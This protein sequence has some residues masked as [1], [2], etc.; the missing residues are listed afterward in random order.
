MGRNSSN[1]KNKR[2]IIVLGIAGRTPFAGVAW[3][4]L[5]YLEGLRR[6]GHDVYYIEDTLQW[7][8]DLD[9]NAKT[10]DSGYTVTYIARLMA[11]CGMG[12][13]WAYRAAEQN[14]RI[15]GLSESEFA[16]VFEQAD[17]LIN[18][19]AS[20]ELHGEHPRVP[21]RVYLETDPVLPQ[22]QV[23]QGR[24]FRIDLLSAHTHHFTYAENLGAPDCRVP[25]GPFL[26]RPTRQPVILDWWPSQT[27]RLPSANGCRF[28][29]I[30][31]WQQY[32]RDI[33]W[34][35]EIYTWSKY[36]EFLKF[37]KL[38]RLS[39]ESL[40]LALAC[41]DVEAIRLMTS[42][43]WRIVD[44]IPLSKHFLPYH[45]YILSSRG[46]FT[47]AK[48]QNIRLRSGW[49]SD[50]SACYLAAGRPVVTQ[51]TGFANVLPTG[52]GLF[53]FNAME[54]ILTAFDAIRSDYQKHSRAAR[55]IAQ[56]YFCAEKVLGK[57]LKD[58]G[59]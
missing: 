10:D 49:F 3:Q 40:E 30:G 18:V 39:G 47:V 13:R 2:R 53:A 5:H 6:L 50:R 20:T 31:S 21:I 7:P 9:K 33:E 54:Q 26:Y 12:D 34:E 37:I 55:E 27:L 8:L 24:S 17:A 38:P 15:Y 52:E 51:D 32:G 22:I 44:A 41:D 59:L 56:E 58:V 46:E 4:V 42:H 1:V 16:R 11:W 28:T 43:G 19:P 29:T 48:D 25:L 45:D 14:G 57:L 35:G 23:A 36:H